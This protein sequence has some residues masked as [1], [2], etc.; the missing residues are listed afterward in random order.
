MRSVRTKNVAYLSL[1]LIFLLGGCRTWDG[2]FIKPGTDPIN[3]KI[4]T[5]NLKLEDYQTAASVGNSTLDYRLND[6]IMLFT[7]EAEQNL[8]DP[9]GDKYGTMSLR[10][11]I[12][13]ARFGIG[14]MLLSSLL[15]T[16][17]N[18]MG[19]PFMNI[20]YKLSA[21]V[22]ITDSNKKLIGMY[23]GQ[24]ESSVKVA[25]YYGYS[26]WNSS[27]DRKAYTDALTEALASI[28]SKIRSD[29]A[30]LNEKLSVAGTERKKQE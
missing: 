30:M 4:L 1:C 12:V 5:L 18:V 17:P 7:K 11:N 20:R 28:R 26:L 9:F 10:T 3:P 15:F 27:A 14:N 25:Y 2:S 6:G 22:R 13:V 19:F 23:Q 21:E 29:A 16:L 8:M 24:G